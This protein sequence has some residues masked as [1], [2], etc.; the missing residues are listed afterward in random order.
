MKVAVSSIIAFAGLAFVALCLTFSG[1]T[2][3]PAWCTA[4]KMVTDLSSEIGLDKSWDPLSLRS[5]FQP[6]VSPPKCMDEETPIARAMPLAVD[7][8]MTT[9]SPSNCFI[10]DTIRMI[11]D[12]LWNRRKEP[13][14][15]PLAVHVTS[16]P[17]T[18]DR[19]PITRKA[20]LSVKKLIAEGT[21]AEVQLVL[22]WK[23]NTRMPMVSLPLNKFTYWVAE[24]DRLIHSGWASL[25]DLLSLV[26]KLNHA[27]HLIPLAH[28]FIVC[29][30][31]KAARSQGSRKRKVWFSR[32]EK[33]DLKLWKRFLQ[34]ALNGVSL[35][36]MPLCQ[37]SF[38]TWTNSCPHGLG[39]ADILGRAWRIRILRSSP[40]WGRNRV[41]NCSELLLLLACMHLNCLS[42]FFLE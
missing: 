5:L 15:V 27:A 21:L 38:I 36:C 23:L 40:I 30:R 31:K 42:L 39:G 11:L 29:L 24:I 8:P 35:N 18:G 14:V 32:E 22:G 34:Q 4:S 16:R 37:P 10:D 20:L 13:C 6:E 7:I 19:E 26:G 41:N 33:E 3:L 2:N 25:E 9:T 17:H 12:T 1:S 28:H